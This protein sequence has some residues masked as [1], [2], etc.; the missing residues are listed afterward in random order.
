[1]VATT[2]I[3][4]LQQKSLVGYTVY[5]QSTLLFQPPFSFGYNQNFFHWINKNI[6]D[7]NF[8]AV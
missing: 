5:Q 3:S 8:V 7:P 2:E 4:L 6:S 1:M